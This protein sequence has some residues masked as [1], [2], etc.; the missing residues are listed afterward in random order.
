MPDGSIRPEDPNARIAEMHVFRDALVVYSKALER[1]LK[2]LDVEK[3]PLLR[4]DLAM[5]RESFS[6]H[7]RERMNQ[8]SSIFEMEIDVAEKRGEAKGEAKTKAAIVSGMHAFAQTQAQMRRAPV[9]GHSYPAAGTCEC[10]R[11][12]RTDAERFR[13]VLV[14]AL[15]TAVG[16]IVMQVTDRFFGGALR[17]PRIE[18]LVA[19]G[20]AL[21]RVA[22]SALVGVAGSI[23]ADDGVAQAGLDAARAELV[24]TFTVMRAEQAVRRG[25][26]R[27]AGN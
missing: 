2:D 5:L 24:E 6:V 20:R 4:E 7:A 16:M 8:A 13:G 15:E 25:R 18:A 9:D 23:E 27:K 19:V 11:D 21:G 22:G 3:V 14:G 12:H 26:V 1:A 17:M 10:G